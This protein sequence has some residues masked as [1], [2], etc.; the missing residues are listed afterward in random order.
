[1]NFTLTTLTTLIN[2]LVCLYFLTFQNGQ[3]VANP[4]HTLTALSIKGVQGIHAAA[5]NEVR[6]KTRNIKL[7]FITQ[8]FPDYLKIM[9]CRIHLPE[10]SLLWKRQ[11]NHSCCRTC[12]FIY[13][14]FLYRQPVIELAAFIKETHPQDYSACDIQEVLPESRPN[15]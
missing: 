9:L 14:G 1:M 8:P 11:N 7:T 10:N 2:I 15:Q 12:V 4:D 13:V 6:P 3:R 5:S